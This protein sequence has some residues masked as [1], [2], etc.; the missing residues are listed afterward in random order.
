MSF[1]ESITKGLVNM[2]DEARKNTELTRIERAKQLGIS[3]DELKALDFVK[4]EENHSFNPKIGKNRDRYN[5]SKKLEEDLIKT[6]PTFASVR[7]SEHQESISKRR[8]VLEE[9]I[10]ELEERILKTSMDDRKRF[11][12]NIDILK[13]EL[14]KLK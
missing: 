2:D 11:Q 12:D 9:G 6:N 14:S 1:I 5:E 10:K 3:V 4:D 13:Q 8:K 7:E